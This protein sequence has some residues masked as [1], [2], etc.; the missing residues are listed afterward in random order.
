MHGQRRAMID[1]GRGNMPFAVIAVSLLL[2]AGVAGA[3][4]ADH[5]RAGAGIGQTEQGTEAID[6]ALDIIEGYINQE[7]GI[8]ILDVSRDES[9]GSLE[10]RTAVFERRAAEW[11]DGHFPMMSRGTTAVL[12][13]RDVEL[14]AE[15]MG[16]MG[17]DGTVGGYI[18]AY[19]HAQGT[20]RVGIS[21]S[22]GDATR[23]L[24][25][26]TDGSYALPLSSEQ[27]SIFERMVEGG[28]I[29]ISQIM[30]YELESL[31]QY[32]VM[33]GYG[34]ESVYGPKGTASIITQEDVR[35]AYG[36]ALDIINTI[37]FRDSD[38]GIHDAVDIADLMVEE[39]VIDRASFY[40]QCLMSVLDDMALKWFDYLCGSYALDRLHLSHSAN[41]AALNCL[42]RFFSGNDAFSAQSYI[43]RVMEDQGIDESLYRYPGSGTTTLEIGGYV[44]TVENPTKDIMDESW[45]RLFS[46]HYDMDGPDMQDAIENILNSA[47]AA[48]YSGEYEPYK[49]RLGP[50]DEKPF[51]DVLCESYRTLISDCQDAIDGILPGIVEGESVYDP[52][53]AAIAET[54][55]RHADDMADCDE[56]RSRIMEKLFELPD[57]DVYELMESPEVERAVHS[58]LS[59]VHSDLSVYDSLRRMEG[60]NTSVL[61]DI[62]LEIAGFGLRLSGLGSDMD[63]RAELL[64]D[65]ILANSPMNPY[66]GIIDL[67]GTEGFALMDG[68]DNIMYERL[69][70]TMTNDP[71]VS[72]P[73]VATRKCCHMTG[74]MEDMT[75]GYSTTF[76]VR[77][78][79][80][81]DYRIE[82]M[83]QLSE[84]L[85]SGVTAASSGTVMNDIVIEVSVVSGWALSGVDY[86]PSVTLA[87]DIWEKLYPFLEPIIEPLREI[88]E[89]VRGVIEKIN[90]C[91]MEIGRYVADILEDIYERI[92]GPLEEI[93]RWIDE[94]IGEILGEEALNLFYS[95][96]LASQEIRFEYMGYTFQLKF[97][98]ASLASA[99][100]T[101]FVASLSGPI[102][103]LDFTVSVTAK[104][105]GEMH[106]N[107]VFVTGSATV[108]S[109]DW[110]VKMGLDPL[111][112]SS[113]H[114][115]TV[116]A[117]VR[118]TDITI[119]M[120]DLEDYSELGIKLSSIPGVGQ[121]LSNIPIPG[122]GLNLGL[123]AG[124][125]LKYTAPVYNGLLINE[126]ESN[127]KGNDTS[128]EWVE[129]F[130]NTDKAIDLDGY[131]L[132]AASDRTR[133][134]MALSGTIAPGEFMVIETSFSMVNSSG[135]LTKNGEGLT[136]KD[137]DGV[138]VDKTGTHKDESDDGKTWQRTYD[139]SGEWTFKDG[140][141]GRS[142]GNYVSG[143]LLTVE[144]A[145]EIVWGSVEDAFGSVGSITD[146]ESMQEVVKL[147][148][149][150]SVDR[151]IKKVSGCLVEASVF[152]KIDIKDPTSTASGGIRV[153]L[154][155]DHELA[156]DVLKFIAGKIE[157]VAL[158][159]KNPYKI[160]PIGMFTDNIDLEVTVDAKIQTPGI[161]SANIDD[162]PKID[163]GVTFRANISAI[164]GLFGKDVGRPGIECGVRILD[165]PTALI[166]P[167]MSP[168][169]G[170]D[171]DL[172]LL[173]MT[174]E[175]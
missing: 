125:S 105:K 103:G 151:L 19:L 17:G 92:M 124:F 111:M 59:K 64:L 29:S 170:M 110:K 4:V 117:D 133:K 75:A 73:E 68:S 14:T 114:M 15:S 30:T 31:A 63:E 70:G 118:G 146:L 34:A 45:I 142:N 132:I 89:M 80:C 100:K 147:T 107:N 93:N 83:S 164:C 5:G 53:Y 95:L 77:V 33:S 148:I 109:D 8:M 27:G 152:V 173:R 47:A 11:I 22:F 9:L 174:V 137:P 2:M 144:V 39:L 169:K 120:P 141:M 171:H 165:C 78:R 49:V 12:V 66:S 1:D 38:G 153:A 79:D 52:F 161:L 85:G 154:R 40:G 56:L 41:D 90:A 128:N 143:K 175:W 121:M 88:M 26:S 74:F 127:P 116:S 37:C 97:N 155:C 130:N 50:Y 61:T 54:V 65:E 156:E 21:S 3:V 16:M 62:L 101:L 23:D 82:A 167:T 24:T 86:R 106:P 138:V 104:V 32:R 72:E 115:V 126:F 129:L 20:V 42:I 112:K 71:I 108:S 160:D 25:V 84:S 96:N 48:L 159:M 158:S 135:K 136:L 28:G 67:P 35:K 6:D 87:D 119:V 94:K 102:G 113:K 46:L 57:A 13:E 7:L 99:T 166:P 157:S 98:L 18:P 139:G 149:K 76:Q 134:N 162:V 44:I 81:I 55:G 69:I 122:I 58:Y 60:G 123:D 150:N 163:L 131:R 168:K 172:W 91:L 145:K 10:E 36:N 51:I 43:E 140:T